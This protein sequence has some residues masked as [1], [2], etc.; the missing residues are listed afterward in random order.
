M[1]CSLIIAYLLFVFVQLTN[2]NR[3]EMEIAVIAS[4]FDSIQYLLQVLSLF[5]GA[6]LDKGSAKMSIDPTYNIFSKYCPSPICI[7]STSAIR[8]SPCENSTLMI[9][10]FNNSNKWD[11]GLK[12]LVGYRGH[13]PFYFLLFFGC[14][15]FALPFLKLLHT[16][17]LISAA[18]L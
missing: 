2:S 6:W 9:I 5:Y 7:Y 11:G 17:P 13:T 15:L 10:D 8:I 16:A 4:H 14:I 1:S 18:E 3:F 12:L